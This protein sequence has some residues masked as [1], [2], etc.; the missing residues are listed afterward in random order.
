M[1]R[2][3]PPDDRARQAQLIEQ[4][5]RVLADSPPKDIAFPRSGG[6]FIS[7]QL[8]DDVQRAVRTMQLRARLHVLPVIQEP[9]EIARVDR[10]DLAA[11]PAERHPVNARE[12]PAVAPLDVAVL[13]GGRRRKPA[14]KNLAFRFETEQRG[15]HNVRGQGKSARETALRLW[16][17]GFKPATQRLCRR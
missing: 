4:L 9:H 8:L 13:S 2:Q 11:Q 3:S 15:V 14:A 16:P 12:H 10:F 17:A 6:H 1:R 5:G 7:L